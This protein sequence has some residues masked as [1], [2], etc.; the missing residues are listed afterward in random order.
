MEAFG[1]DHLGLE[2]IFDFILAV[3]FEVPVGIVKVPERRERLCACFPGP[4][5]RFSCSKVTYEDISRRYTYVGFRLTI[6]SLHIG[7]T[8]FP[9]AEVAGVAAGKSPWSR[10]ILEAR[11]WLPDVGGV[12]TPESS[13]RLLGE[14]ERRRALDLWP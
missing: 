7:Q 4:S 8:G 9:N 6:S 2:P 5:H 11:S 10:D 12:E 13:E 3:I 14:G 1:F